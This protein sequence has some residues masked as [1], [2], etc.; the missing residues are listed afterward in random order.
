[1][2]KLCVPL[3][4][5]AHVNCGFTLVPSQVNFAGIFAPSRKPEDVTVSAAT[6]DELLE[7]DTLLDELLLELDT[8]LEELLLELVELLELETLLDELLLELTELIELDEL[9]EAKG[10]G[11]LPVPPPLQAVTAVNAI[12]IKLLIK[13]LFANIVFL[14]TDPR[15]N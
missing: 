1:M 12:I 14:Q 10:G 3:G 11:L 15:T 5:L 6:L 13:N 7:L 9:L 4:T 2:A 8:L